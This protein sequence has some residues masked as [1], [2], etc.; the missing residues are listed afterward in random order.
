MLQDTDGKWTLVTARKSTP[1]TRMRG[2]MGTSSEAEG[3]FRAADRKVP[4]FISNVHIDTSEKDITEYILK[5]TQIPVKLE[6]IAMK[7]Q[8]S[9]N[10]YKF[11][12]EESKINM[13]L[14]DK[15]WPRGIIFRRFV[16]FKYKFTT[17][18]AAA[19]SDDGPIKNT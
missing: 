13:F 2:K 17:G 4:I 14:D 19:S 8:D 6:K 18:G 1:K 10:A 12:V 16:H 7:I 15:L 5:K 11:F 3:K 9:H